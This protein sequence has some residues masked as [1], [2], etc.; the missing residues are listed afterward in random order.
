MDVAF[1]AVFSQGLWII[2]GSLVAFLVGQLLDVVL[3]QRIKR[4][5]GERWLWLRATGSTLV[6]Q[7]VDSFLV[8]VIAF[9]L[10]PATQWGLGTILL[11]GLV[12]YGYKVV[13]ALLLT[14]L[15]YLLHHLIDRYLGEPLATQM[16]RQAM[17]EPGAP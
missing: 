1:N 5:T 2:V 17:G 13:M 3:F 14:P 10:N 16:K 7:F 11:L 12:K 15:I 9:H 4:H 6:S 8:L